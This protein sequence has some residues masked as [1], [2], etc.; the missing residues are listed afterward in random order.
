MFLLGWI[1]RPFLFLLAFFWAFHFLWVSRSATRLRFHPP[2]RS[3][4]GIF[5][6]LACLTFGLFDI[7]PFVYI[8]SGL[9]GVSSDG[10]P[11]GGSLRSPFSVSLNYL[12]SSTMISG[13]A[14]L[15][16]ICCMGFFHSSADCLMPGHMYTLHA[17]VSSF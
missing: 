7:L 10:V 3:L 15:V 1:L 2:P 11:M 8:T 4:S 5:S 6:S 13:S 17:C 12:T 9:V 14:V 16:Y